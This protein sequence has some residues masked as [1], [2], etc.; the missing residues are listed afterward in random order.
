[1][2]FLEMNLTK[3]ASPVYYDMQFLFDWALT[4]LLRMMEMEKRKAGKTR[5]TSRPYSMAATRYSHAATPARLKS[6]PPQ[7]NVAIYYHV[8][9]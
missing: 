9:R 4:T 2:K 6:I 3:H 7:R 5:C 8:K 1:M